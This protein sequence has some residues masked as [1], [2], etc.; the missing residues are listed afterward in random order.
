MTDDQ[1]SGIFAYPI[2]D[3]ADLVPR[4][5]LRLDPE[6]ELDPFSFVELRNLQRGVK[7]T[8]VHGDTPENRERIACKLLY[9]QMVAYKEGWTFDPALYQVRFCPDSPLSDGSMHRRIYELLPNSPVPFDMGV[10]PEGRVGFKVND[11]TSEARRMSHS[12]VDGL[13][14]KVLKLF[15]RR[16]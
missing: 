14:E 2:L 10:S 7:Y 12:E 6:R 8:A 4:E 1:R 13:A 16:S 9:F 3:P 11:Q 15:P 5:Q